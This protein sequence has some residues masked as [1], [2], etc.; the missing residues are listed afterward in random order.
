[1]FLTDLSRAIGIELFDLGPNDATFN[2]C[3]DSDLERNTCKH[4]IKSDNVRRLVGKDGRNGALF[5]IY[6][7]DEV[8]LESSWSYDR[9]LKIVI[10]RTFKYC[11]HI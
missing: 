4:F 7:L 1:M 2:I 6:F 5:S 11:P 9:D 3:K 10:A 8:S